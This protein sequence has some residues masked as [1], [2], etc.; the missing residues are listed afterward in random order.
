M[1]TLQANQINN[2]GEDPRNRAQLILNHTDFASVTDDILKGNDA[3]KPPKSWWI[4]LAVSF[5]LM[6][7]LGILIGYL[8]VTGVG[9]W[10]NNNPVMWGYPIVN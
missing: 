3:S 4:A 2:T 7:L 1:T 9:V 6:S 10:G 5:S 8:V